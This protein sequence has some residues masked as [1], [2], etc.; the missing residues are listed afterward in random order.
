L[1]LTQNL[2]RA[3]KNCAKPIAGKMKDLCERIAARGLKICRWASF[4]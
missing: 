3:G 2:L 4:M 1:R